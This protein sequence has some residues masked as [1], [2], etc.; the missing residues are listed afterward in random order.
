MFSEVR[1]EDL[2]L[3]YGSPSARVRRE[4]VYSS[5][6]PRGK[7]I[8]P[9]RKQLLFFKLQTE[10]PRKQHALTQIRKQNVDQNPAEQERL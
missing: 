6:S 2:S 5:L 9:F 1:D 10:R 8:R 4:P 7:T 3:R